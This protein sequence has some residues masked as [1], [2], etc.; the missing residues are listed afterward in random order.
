MGKKGVPESH[1]I[2]PVSAAAAMTIGMDEPLE[3]S[4]ATSGGADAKESDIRH[5]SWR[6]RL[7]QG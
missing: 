5:Q 6:D 3:W 2:D 1:P 4:W 7:G